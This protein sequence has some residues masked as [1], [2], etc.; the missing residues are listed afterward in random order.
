MVHFKTAQKS[1]RGGGGGSDFSAQMS[2]AQITG[3]NGVISHGFFP[4]FGACFRDLREFVRRNSLFR[5]F[6]KH[7]FVY[8]IFRVA[9][10]SLFPLFCLFTVP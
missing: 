4:S 7:Y 3:L 9:F 8:S 2:C 5:L 1:T 6:V 10:F